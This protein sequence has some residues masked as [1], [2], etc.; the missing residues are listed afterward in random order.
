MRYHAFTCFHFQCQCTGVC[1]LHMRWD[2]N[3]VKII[4][5]SIAQIIKLQRKKIMVVDRVIKRW[6]FKKAEVSWHHQNYRVKHLNSKPKMLTHKHG[7]SLHTVVAMDLKQK[8]TNLYFSFLFHIICCCM[9]KE[10][11]CHYF[12]LYLT[13]FS[14]CLYTYVYGIGLWAEFTVFY[15]LVEH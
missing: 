7:W 12:K 3:I 4:N 8:N 10:D 2:H 9:D 5:L 11:E 15:T 13:N 14:T 1:R 6:D